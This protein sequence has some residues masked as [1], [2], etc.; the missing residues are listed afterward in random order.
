MSTRKFEYFHFV[1]QTDDENQMK[2]FRYVLKNADYY[3]PVYIYHTQDRYS[4]QDLQDYS[5]RNDGATPNWQVGDLKDPHIHCMVHPGE[6]LTPNML[7]L[8][9]F[10]WAYVKPEVDPRDRLEYFLHKCLRC[11]D[12]VEKGYKHEY[13]R[14]DLQGDSRVI[15]MLDSHAKQKLSMKRFIQLAREKKTL[16]DS[17][18]ELCDSDDYDDRRAFDEYFSDGALRQTVIAIQNQNTTLIARESARKHHEEQ[19]AIVDDIREKLAFVPK[20]IR[21]QTEQTCKELDKRFHFEPVH[22]ESPSVKDPYSAVWEKAGFPED[23]PG[24]EWR[25]KQVVE[26][27]QLPIDSLL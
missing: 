9:F 20:A 14:E 19:C 23:K 26:G 22:M 8:R 1:L 21:A 24:Y 3:R 5:E 17:L 18:E 4:D 13:D 16:A 6:K 27:K 25:K 15:A 11:V 2:V 12:D 7:Y 10:R